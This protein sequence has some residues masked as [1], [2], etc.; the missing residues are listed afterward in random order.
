MGGSAS[1]SELFDHAAMLALTSDDTSHRAEL[2]G[3]GR[4]RLDSL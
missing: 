3:L 2:N 4:L 1:Q